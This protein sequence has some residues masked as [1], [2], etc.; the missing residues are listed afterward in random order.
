M[1][2]RSTASFWTLLPAYAASFICWLLSAALTFWLILQLRINLIDISV[3]VIDTGPWVLGAV[4]KFGM[5]LLGLAWLVAVLFTEHYLRQGV[6]RN[7]LWLR[8]A[9]VLGVELVL[10][11]LSYLLQILIT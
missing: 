9:W 7:Q 4:D 3:F 2:D 1:Q 8:V 10:L 11:A 6:Q 5:L